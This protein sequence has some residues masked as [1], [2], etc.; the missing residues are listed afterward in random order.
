MH[1]RPRVNMTGA[2]PQHVEATS[3][4]R[5]FW[6]KN[7]SAGCAIATEATMDPVLHKLAGAPSTVWTLSSISAAAN[8]NATG[9]DNV[10]TDGIGRTHV[11]VDS[12]SSSSSSN[13]IYVEME[14]R[15][16]NK[17]ATRLPESIFVVFRPAFDPQMPN[18]NASSDA[19]TERQRH[20]QQLAAMDHGWLLQMFNES[21]ITLNPTD[22]LV[23][24]TGSGGA[25]HTRCISAA[26]HTGARYIDEAPAASLLV[27][28]AGKGP[29]Q[30]GMGS[31]FL[32][33]LDVPCVSTGYPSPFPTPRDGVPD[34]RLGQ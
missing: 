1:F 17:T 31:M 19:V 5:T 14:V 7:G 11:P 20:F 25:P 28:A 26:T 10:N 33:S 22:V 4:L 16:F 18:E 30:V 12:S 8:S 34:M 23:N 27:P 6:I 13:G 2:Q 9:E 29:R 32:S 15:M 3:V 21:N 24:G